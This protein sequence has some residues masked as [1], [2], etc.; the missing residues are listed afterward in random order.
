MH[1][2]LNFLHSGHDMAASNVALP[3]PPNLTMSLQC[4]QTPQSGKNYKQFG[5]VLY[6]LFLV[7][8]NNI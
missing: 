6:L 8:I 1:P 5:Q 2:N 3:F 4:K 7:S